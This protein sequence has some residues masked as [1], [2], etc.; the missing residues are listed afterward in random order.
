LQPSSWYFPRNAEEPKLTGRKPQ[1]DPKGRDYQTLSNGNRIEIRDAGKST[2]APK[3]E[4][5]DVIQNILE[6]I[7]FK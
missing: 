3:V 7:T 1:Y 4:I 5:S 6:K 2:G